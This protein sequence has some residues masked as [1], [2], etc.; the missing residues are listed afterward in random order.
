M[1][2]AVLDPLFA[3]YGINPT[4]ASTLQA[5]SADRRNQFFLDWYDSLMRYAGTDRVDHWMRDRELDAGDHPAA[6]LGRGHHHRPARRDRDRRSR[7]RRQR[8]LVGRLRTLVS[9]HGVGVASLMVA[10][11][12][13]NGVMGVAPNATVI[14]YNPFDA[15]GTASWSAIRTGV[16]SL[17]ERNASIINMSLGISGYTLHPDWR[18]I[19]FDPA[20]WQ[21]AQRTGSSS[22]PPA[23]T[24]QPDRERPVGLQPRSQPDHRRLDPHRRHHLELL[25]PARHRPA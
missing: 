22:W 2:Q 15:T 25:E 18:K 16:L 20:V 13:R 6:G 4:N 19:F 3:R 24:A 12:D 8:R 7:H 17:A 23:M 14:A 5:L 10:A 11:H 9:G 21:R 1:R